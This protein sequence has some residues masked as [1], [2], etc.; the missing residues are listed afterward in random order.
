MWRLDVICSWLY[1]L[2]RSNPN[3]SP[4]VEAEKYTLDSVLGRTKELN[5]MY[6]QSLSELTKTKQALQSVVTNVNF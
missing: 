3:E 6:L 2:K 5:L 4:L 1:R